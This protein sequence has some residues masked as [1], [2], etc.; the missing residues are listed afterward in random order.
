MKGNLP[1]DQEKRREELLRE[2]F[3]EE[4]FEQMETERT[5]QQQ[6]LQQQLHP[7]IVE[8]AHEL[9]EAAD[10]DDDEGGIFVPPPV[11][12]DEQQAQTHAAVRPKTPEEI[13]AKNTHYIF[14]FG[15]TGSGKST[16]LT[17]INMYMRQHYRVILNQTENQTGIRLIHE[18]MRDIESGRFPQPTSVGSIT[19]YDTA[20]TMNDQDVNLTF[21]EMAGEDLK[22]IDVDEGDEGLSEELL[23]YLRCPGISISFLMVADYERVVNRK[24]DKLILQFLSYLYNEGIDMSRVGVV[25]SKFDQG[26][27]DLDVEQIIKTYLPQVDKW[28]SS[29]DIAHPRVFPFSIGRIN[30]YANQKD[31]IAEIDLE[32]CSEIVPWLHQVLSLP[33]GQ[34]TGAEAGGGS[35][36]KRLRNLLGF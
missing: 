8:P 3:G 7:A 4:E 34:Q 10:T 13:L 16:V 20:F 21:L 26:R 12:M 31:D 22:K 6:R 5:Q 1:E 29:D 24:E 27:T 15:Y 19:E 33:G 9:A 23:A 25:L 32:D 30:S 36:K 35:V 11:D 14:I 18:M 28:L 2:I 17:A